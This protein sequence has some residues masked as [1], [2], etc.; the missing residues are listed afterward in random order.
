MYSQNECKVSFD[1]KTS[2]TQADLI[3][4]QGATKKIVKGWTFLTIMPWMKGQ[5]INELMGDCTIENFNMWNVGTQ[6][7]AIPSKATS[8]QIASLLG[9][10]ISDGSIGTTYLIKTTSNCELMKDISAPPTLPN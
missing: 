5:T 3:T 6:N 4:G 8:E 7:W 9:V 1:L 10:E 2:A